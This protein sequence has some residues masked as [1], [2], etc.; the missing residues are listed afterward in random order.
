ML[1]S[2]YILLKN[3][4]YVKI[5]CEKLYKVQIKVYFNYIYI[6]LKIKQDF[7]RSIVSIVKKSVFFTGMRIHFSY[8][9]FLSRNMF[10]LKETRYTIRYSLKISALYMKQFIMFL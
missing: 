3:K 10:A 1:I 5:Q 2:K 6:V 7:V 4:I 8:L 9:I